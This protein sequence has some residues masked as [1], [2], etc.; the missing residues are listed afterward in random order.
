MWHENIARALKAEWEVLRRVPYHF[1]AAIVVVGFLLWLVIDRE[2]A[3]RLSNAESTIALLERQLD[4]KAPSETPS[5][6]ASDN[7]EGRESSFNA[8]NLKLSEATATDVTPAQLVA[9]TEGRTKLQSDE[10]VK[11]YI[12]KR[13]AVSGEV[14]NVSEYQET[15][16]GLL[17]LISDEIITFC[18]FRSISDRLIAM[19]P[20]DSV[21]VQGIFAGLAPAG[22]DLRECEV[23]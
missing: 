5:T 3:T 2:Y 16:G 11:K 13:L 1:L 17:A 20:G 9:L 23:D 4:R 7:R 19:R 21:K 10:I 22:I 14:K 8:A 15:R 6:A 18:E 12:G